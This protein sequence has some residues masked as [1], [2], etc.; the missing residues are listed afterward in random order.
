MKSIWYKIFVKYQENK[1]ISR[2]Q[3]SFCKHCFNGMQSLCKLRTEELLQK[4]L[5]PVLIFNSYC[6]WVISKLRTIFPLAFIYILKICII[7][8]T[9]ILHPQS[10]PPHSDFFMLY[11][12][13]ASGTHRTANVAFL[14]THFC[15]VFIISLYRII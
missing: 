2:L 8:L 11:V 5:S 1:C 6:C 15:N 14:H 4:E 9:I 10:R 12:N 7:N 13:S 3:V